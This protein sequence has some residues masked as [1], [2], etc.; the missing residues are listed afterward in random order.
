VKQKISLKKEFR[1][2]INGE[3]NDINNTDESKQQSFT[4]ELAT[5]I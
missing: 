4:V 2:Q 3:I 1:T 5:L